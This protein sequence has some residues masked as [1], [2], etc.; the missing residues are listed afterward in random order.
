MRTAWWSANPFN[1]VSDALVF[2]RAR[3]F[4]RGLEVPADPGADTGADMGASACLVLF[5]LT[6]AI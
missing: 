1:P 6:F 2:S 4:L 3:F 5:R